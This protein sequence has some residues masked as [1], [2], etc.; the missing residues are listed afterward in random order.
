MEAFV[1]IDQTGHL[2][3]DECGQVLSPRGHREKADEKQGE[4]VFAV[5]GHSTGGDN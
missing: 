4:R 2:A 3:A 1:G 5:H